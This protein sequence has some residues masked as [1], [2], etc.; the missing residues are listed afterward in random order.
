MLLGVAFAIFMIM[1]FCNVSSFY[2]AFASQVSVADFKACAPVFVMGIKDSLPALGLS[3]AWMIGVMGIPVFNWLPL[4]FLIYLVAEKNVVA[5]PETKPGFKDWCVA[6]ALEIRNLDS[7]PVIWQV[8]VVAVVAHLIGHYIGSHTA[9]AIL[10][11]LAAPC[12]VNRLLIKNE[13]AS[14]MRIKE[15]IATGKLDSMESA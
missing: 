1:K 10:F 2:R 5:Q 11:A 6:R 3:L 15:T 9:T 14:L 12:A 4:V 13:V 7:C 8:S